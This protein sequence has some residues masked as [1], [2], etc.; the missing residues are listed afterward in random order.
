MAEIKPSDLTLTSNYV[1]LEPGNYPARTDLT[2]HKGT[3][4]T[5]AEALDFKLNIPLGV[6]NS[7]SVIYIY[8]QGTVEIIGE[9][10]C[11]NKLVKPGIYSRYEN[12]VIS[13]KK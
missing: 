5:E 8:Q 6:G 1:A 10:Y 11:W 7:N 4:L 3:N 13:Q 12:Y 9:V 2:K